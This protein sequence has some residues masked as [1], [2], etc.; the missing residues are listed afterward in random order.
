[1]DPASILTAALSILGT[2]ATEESTKLAVADLWSA[3]KSAIQRKQGPDSKAIDTIEEVRR[4]SEQVRSLDLTGDPEIAA[5][6]KR[7]ETLVIKQYTFQGNTFN[8]TTFS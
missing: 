1:M 5:V 3:L 7:M 6:L 8:N 2:K 4:L